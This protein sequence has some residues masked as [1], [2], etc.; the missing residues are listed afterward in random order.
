MALSSDREL[1]V[2]RGICDGRSNQQIADTLFLSVN[3]VK[4]HMTRLFTKLQV[5]SRTEAIARV[6]AW[7]RY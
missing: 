1:D 7:L 5:G 6:N 3:T 4:T 2:L